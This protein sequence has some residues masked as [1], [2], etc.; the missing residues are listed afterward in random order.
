MRAEELTQAVRAFA[1]PLADKPRDYDALLAR[2]ADARFVLLG[3]STEGT[4][5]FYRV[6][7]TITRRLILE[8]GFSAVATEADWSDAYRVNRYVRD[9]GMD[10]ELDDALAGFRRFPDWR[11]RNVDVMELVKWLRAHNDAAARTEDK[12]GYYGIDF[13]FPSPGDPDA[14]PVEED[15]RFVSEQKL[16]IAR[17]GPPGVPWSWNARQS[18][19]AQTLEALAAHL[20]ATWSRQ[21]IVVWGHN[22][23]LGD[24]RATEMTRTG[25]I[26]LGQLLRERLGQ[27]DVVSIGF[28]TFAGTLT[29]ALAHS[30]GA[31]RQILPP[32]QPASYEALF[33]STGLPAFQLDLDLRQRPSIAALAEPRL[34]RALGVVYM[35]KSE[36]RNHYIEARLSDQFDWLV[37]I[38]QTSAVVP[39]DNG[40]VWAGEAPEPAAD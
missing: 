32:A 12:V 9:V 2:V 34:E 38:D 36:G 5:E 13:R 26:S 1:L 40:A 31:R 14:A 20:Q 28:C 25:Q 27:T 4:R 18:H 23:R 35:P 7:G 29:C 6:R 10:C 22:T 16:R 24:A 17:H 39:L 21:R 15:A 3:E 33:H 19:M 37:H 11:W 8:K 30:A